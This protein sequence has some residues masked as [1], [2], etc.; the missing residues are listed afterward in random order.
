MSFSKAVASRSTTS[1]QLPAGDF[2]I[3]GV[4]LT[5]AV[6]VPGELQKLRVPDCAARTL[7]A[8]SDLES[9]RGQRGRQ[10]GL[11]GTRRPQ[12]SR[13]A[14]YRM[15]LQ[16][17]DQHP[18]QRNS[19]PGRTD[20]DEGLPLLAVP[21]HQSQSGVADQA[22][23]PGSEL[24][25]VYR[26]RPGRAGRAEGSAAADAARHHG[27][28]RRAEA[29]ERADQPP[30]AGSFRHAGHRKRHRVAPQSEGDAQAEPA[31]RAGHR[32]QHG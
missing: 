2:R 29:S 21:D 1:R 11:Q 22:S 15:A 24:Q 4:D 5:G 18:G 30:R 9:R 8:R 17:A 20:R 6:M 32:R 3:V 12:A 13:K 27:H 23:Q 7:P 16:R 19:P 31:G 25:P 10:R 26:Q 14:I 28:R